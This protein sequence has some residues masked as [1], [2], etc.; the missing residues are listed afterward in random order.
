[1]S[2][3]P[4]QRGSTVVLLAVSLLCMIHSP[5]AAKNEQKRMMRIGDE[6]V[7]E[8]LGRAFVSAQQL[9]SNKDYKQAEPALKT[10]VDQSPNTVSIR[11]KYGFVLLQQGKFND[12]VT[13]AQKCV[14]LNPN[15]VGGWSLLG[16]ASAELKLKDQ[17]KDAYK[18][19]LVLEPN[20]EN[21]DIIREHLSDLEDPQPPQPTTEEVAAN[22][23]INQQNRSVIKLNRALALCDSAVKHG[24]Q[25][26]FE[27]G[28]QECR[29]ALK[30]APDSDRIK[31]NFVVFLNN[32][33]ASCV[34]SQQLSRAESLMKE[35]IAVQSQ[36]GV[37][38]Q[39]RL[40]TLKNYLALLNF[41]GRAQEAK[42]VELQMKS[43][44]TSAQ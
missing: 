13:Q 18:R 31:E 28:M 42:Q 25:K 5:T 4:T 43:M 8:E 3:L 26:Q 23:K 24:A 29:E 33:A 14:E 32:Y 11:Y 6:I 35:A 7:S 34:Q 44:A 41:Q 37:P 39:L 30:I 16:E 21:A 40:T 1:M 10:L 19:A 36:G 17:A 22:E 2:S 9:I 12:V 38:T 27:Q 15:F 20:G